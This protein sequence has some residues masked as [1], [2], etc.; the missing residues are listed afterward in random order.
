MCKPKKPKF[1]EQIQKETDKAIKGVQEAAD[2]ELTGLTESLKT[3]VEGL[4]ESVKTEVEGA[5]KSLGMNTEQDLMPKIDVDI[6]DLSKI[7]PNLNQ[8][9][10]KISLTGLA[11]EVP[12]IGS[13]IQ[14]GAIDAGSALQQNLIAAG[15]AMQQNAI[16]FGS[17]ISEGQSNPTLEGLASSATKA[18]ET[19]IASLSGG[20]ETNFE[21]IT[22]TTEDLV[23]SNVAGIEA[24][25]EDTAE[26][27]VNAIKG[28]QLLL[29]QFDPFGGGGGGGQATGGD[30]LAPAPTIGDPDELPMEQATSKAGQMSEEE[31]LRRMRRLLLN[32]Y[33]REDTILSGGGDTQSRRRYAL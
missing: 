3:E 30:N 32:R 1:V 17:T 7:M 33:G 27:N 28:L 23:S 13:A 10:T 31:R 14:Q 25:P 24:L 21:G 19:N 18:T 16:D 8:D 22:Q 5:G 6:N 9:F 12:K 15:S 2:T 20:L 26:F 4:T 11:A 29:S